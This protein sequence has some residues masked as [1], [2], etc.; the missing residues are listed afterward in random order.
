M[1]SL[2]MAPLLF[3]PSHLMLDKLCALKACRL[4]D[5][6]CLT[7]SSNSRR[8]RLDWRRCPDASFEILCKAVAQFTSLNCD[9]CLRQTSRISCGERHCR[10]MSAV[11]WRGSS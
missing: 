3:P 10:V 5:S 1:H 4:V 8:S 9:L 11:I 2:S 6:R 7:E